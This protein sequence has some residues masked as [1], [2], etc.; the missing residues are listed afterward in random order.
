MVQDLHSGIIRKKAS[1]QLTRNEINKSGELIKRQDGKAQ[2][3]KTE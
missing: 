2:N 1:R 3:T